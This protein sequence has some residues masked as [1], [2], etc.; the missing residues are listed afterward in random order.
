MTKLATNHIA[1][2]NS[3]SRKTKRTVTVTYSKWPQPVYEC[4]EVALEGEVTLEIDIDRL[5]KELG[6]KALRSKGRKSQEC[7]GAVVVTA[8]VT[9]SKPG[10]WTERKW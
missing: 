7:S 5:L 10:E 6:P 8:R 4:R 1:T 2:T 3:E 9:S